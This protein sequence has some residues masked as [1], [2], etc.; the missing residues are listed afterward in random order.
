MLRRCGFFL[1]EMWWGNDY[2][3]VFS[4]NEYRSGFYDIVFIVWYLGYFLF[5]E[6]YYKDNLYKR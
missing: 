6:V 2:F 4:S 1:V 3:R 5:I